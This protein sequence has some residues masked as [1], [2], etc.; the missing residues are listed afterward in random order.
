[1]TDHDRF[2]PARADESDLLNEMTLAGVRHWGHDVNHPE[3][4]QGLVTALSED[5]S[6]GDA[7]INVIEENGDVIAFYDLRDRGVHTSNLFGCS[8]EST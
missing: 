2:R 3:V 4:Y 5:E 1:M 6:F 7:T 8:K